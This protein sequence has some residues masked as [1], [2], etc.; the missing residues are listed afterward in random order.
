M[1]RFRCTFLFA[2]IAV[3]VLLLSVENFS[4]P[5]HQVLRTM[6]RGPRTNT[7]A[8]RC[9]TAAIPPGWLAGP[10]FSPVLECKNYVVISSSRA[11]LGHRIAAVAIGIALAIDAQAGVILDEGLLYSK[12]REDSDNY[13]FLRRLFNLY[14]FLWTME[15]G[16]QLDGDKQVVGMGTR[17]G[18]FTPLSATS[19]PQALGLIKSGCGHVVGLLTG[20][21]RCI[22]DASG[23]L[24]FCTMSGV[25]GAFQKARPIIA[26]LYATGYYPFLPLS[27]FRDTLESRPSFLIVV[28]HIRNDDITLHDSDIPFWTNLVQGVLAGLDGVPADH[29]VLSQNPIPSDDPHYG[30]LHHM[31]GFKWTNLHGLTVDAAVHH[32]AA[33]DVLVH[34]GSSFSLAAGLAADPSQVAVFCLPKE[35]KTIGDPPYVTYWLEDSIPVQVDGSLAVADVSHMQQRTR[36]RLE[37]RPVKWSR[38][39]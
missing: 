30:F 17:Y 16:I 35:S 3:T 26:Q 38:H 13:P 9:P 6:E 31:L 15:A 18:S 8:E 23:E 11:G 14:A 2:G 34:T 19:V 20:W 28:W 33:A 22:H 32:M 10:P 27:G 1:Q 21:A 12:R 24:D 4:S 39:A 29:C 25:P 37:H 7:G 5:L 36:R